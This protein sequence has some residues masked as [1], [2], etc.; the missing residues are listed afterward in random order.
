MTQTPGRSSLTASAEVREKARIALL[1]LGYTQQ[2]LADFLKLSR[3]T[4]SK[5]FNGSPITVDRYKQI[6]DELGLNWE[7]CLPIE[8]PIAKSQTDSCCIAVTDQEEKTMQ[9]LNRQITVIDSQTEIVKAVIYLKGDIEF[10]EKSKFVD[11]ALQQFPG[12]TIIIKDLKRGSIKV[13][14]EG[15]GKDIEELVN[16]IQSK[17]LTELNGFPIESIQILDANE[18]NNNQRNNI[19]SLSGKFNKPNFPPGWDDPK[20]FI[21]QTIERS[22][23]LSSQVRSQEND[24]NEIGKIIHLTPINTSLLLKIKK[25]E[26]NET[27]EKG[28]HSITLQILTTNQQI[29]LPE[30]L[31][32]LVFYESSGEI[33][34]E[35]LARRKTL[36]SSFVIESKS[37]FCIEVKLGEQIIEKGLYVL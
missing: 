5:F 18:P 6:C 21:N 7:D 37:P 12:H 34:D 13:F 4:V 17:I 24:R 1:R 3:S 15:S 28:L 10:I 16:L 14:I 23:P 33:I 2:V 27:L 25:E 36:R 26:L 31:K 19:I 8:K 22:R 32:I 11:T 29:Q 30:N 20:K 9:T 35:K